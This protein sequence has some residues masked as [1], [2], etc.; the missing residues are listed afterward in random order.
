MILKNG[1]RFYFQICAAFMTNVILL[2]RS[3]TIFEKAIPQSPSE[4]FKRKGSSYFFKTF[5]L[6]YCVKVTQMN[7]DDFSSHLLF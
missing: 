2:H 7:F 1:S 5:F 4:I 3:G 6:Q